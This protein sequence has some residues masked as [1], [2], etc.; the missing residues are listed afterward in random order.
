M[1]SPWRQQPQ[2]RGQETAR[3]GDVKNAGQNRRQEP[4]PRSLA[5]NQRGLTGFLV[6]SVI[7][8]DPG[9]AAEP[10]DPG[11]NLISTNERSA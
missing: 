4:K 9:L 2:G 7:I 3:A 6:P 5:R 11:L 10:S 8:P 1:T